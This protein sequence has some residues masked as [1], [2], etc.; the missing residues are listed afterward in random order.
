MNHSFLALCSYL[1]SPGVDS[2]YLCFTL[3]GYFQSSLKKLQK[4]SFCLLSSAAHS[5]H[6]L[7]PIICLKICQTDV[8]REHFP[9]LFAKGDYFQIKY[10]AAAPQHQ[11]SFLRLVWVF[12]L[13]LAVMYLEPSFARSFVFFCY[14]PLSQLWVVELPKKWVDWPGNWAL[15]TTVV[16]KSLQMA[17][18]SSFVAS[19]H[20]LIALNTVLHL[21]IILICGPIFLPW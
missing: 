20:C 1:S 12:E 17:E 18:S 21:W 7:S 2:M 10:K 4:V 8:R 3:S 15:H 14:V 5:P 19:W 9:V 11:S 13:K 16:L 6:Q